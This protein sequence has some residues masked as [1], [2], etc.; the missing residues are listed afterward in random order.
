MIPMTMVTQTEFARLKGVSKS[1]VT[2]WKNEGRL[3]I[4]G[5]LIDLEA[6]EA[7]MVPGSSHRSKRRV[8]ARPD[9]VKLPPEIVN[10]P[11]SLN[12]PP[13]PLA[14]YPGSMAAML[15]G[16]AGD[17][18]IIMLRSGSSRE[19]VQVLVDEWS[20]TAR[21]S[22]LALLEDDLN[23]PAGFDRWADHP[24]FQ[25]NWFTTWEELEYEATLPAAASAAV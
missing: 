24:A 11:H 23:P 21:H 2:Q 4:I 22:A 3:T 18:A 9:G 19:Q 1:A 10:W 7:T 6:T 17:L 14:D 25:E 8:P 12:S 5:K 13:E 20:R 15:T 16:C